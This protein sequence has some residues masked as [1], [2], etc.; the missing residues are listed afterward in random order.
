MGPLPRELLRHLGGISVLPGRGPPFDPR[1]GPPD[2]P[3]L[4][5]PPGGGPLG[6]IL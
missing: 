1:G 2:S 6:V 3:G 5:G 4:P